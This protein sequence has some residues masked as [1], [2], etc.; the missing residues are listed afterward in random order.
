MGG[1]G[2]SRKKGPVQMGRS[3]VAFKGGDVPRE[4]FGNRDP[5]VAMY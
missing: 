4:S 3:G 2:A 1:G 5:L